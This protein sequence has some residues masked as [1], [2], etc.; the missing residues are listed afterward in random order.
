METQCK[1]SYSRGKHN[2]RIPIQG[3]A[4]GRRVFHQWWVLQLSAVNNPPSSASVQPHKFLPSFK[5][6]HGFEVGLE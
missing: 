1:D 2:A 3:A 6:S 4:Q 5:Q